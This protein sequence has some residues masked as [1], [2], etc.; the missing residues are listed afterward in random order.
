M[1]ENTYENL[2]LTTSAKIFHV[3]PVLRSWRSTSCSVGRI[4]ASAG[5]ICVVL[6]RRIGV[7]LFDGTRLGGV[8]RYHR[9]QRR[10]RRLEHVSV[11]HLPA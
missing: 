1:F 3:L 5:R 6:V 10:V 7:I 4:A 2:S 11:Q 9:R 8:A